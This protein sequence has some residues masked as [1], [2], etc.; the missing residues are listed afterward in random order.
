MISISVCHCPCMQIYKLLQQFRKLLEATTVVYSAMLQLFGK[1]KL[2]RQAAQKHHLKM[3]RS[4]AAPSDL[5]TSSANLVLACRSANYCSS[6]EI[7]QQQFAALPCRYLAKQN[8]SKQLV[9]AACFRF[10]AYLQILES[11]LES[12]LEQTAIK[13]MVDPITVSNAIRN[14]TSFNIKHYYFETV[15]SNAF[16]NYNQQFR[17]AFRMHFKCVRNAF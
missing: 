9:R 17:N 2:G 5:F 8:H 10:F 15:L 14:Y 11:T 3:A 7:L 1:A 4:G 13:Y 6:F 16:R 12:I